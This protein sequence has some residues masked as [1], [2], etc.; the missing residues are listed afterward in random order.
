MAKLKNIKRTNGYVELVQFIPEGSK[1]YDAG[2]KTVKSPLFTWA[3]KLLNWS[4]NAAQV[5]NV[6]FQY[7]H[8]GRVTFAVQLPS[9]EDLERAAQGLL[10]G[11]FVS[12]KINILYG[13]T[14]CHSKETPNK[15]LGRL[16]A[17][18]NIKEVEL[19]IKKLTVEKGMISLECGGLEG[20]RD[21]ME[22][23]IITFTMPVKST[24]GVRF[25]INKASEEMMEKMYRYIGDY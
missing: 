17:R 13:E 14:L 4:E 21:M 9:N 1:D 16:Q 24:K 19:F 18:R 7:K 2:F 8:N 22:K 6:S 23:P 3:G 12:K 10:Q 25:F 20:T 15:L 5:P 11:K